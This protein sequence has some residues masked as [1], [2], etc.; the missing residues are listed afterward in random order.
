MASHSP[1]HGLSLS[2]RAPRLP[3]R[4]AALGHENTDLGDVQGERPGGKP[5]IKLRFPALEAREHEAQLVHGLGGERWGARHWG[6]SL[7]LGESRERDA[8]G[9]E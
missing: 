5:G 4:Y 6:R 9:G 1:S 7:D 8:Y 2:R 3:T